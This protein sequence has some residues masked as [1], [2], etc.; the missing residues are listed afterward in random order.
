MTIGICSA[1]VGAWRD[2]GQREVLAVDVDGLA[3]PQRPQ[4]LERLAEACHPFGRVAVGD[5]EG[6]ELL[7]HRAGPDAEV[8]PAARRVGD[9]HGFTGQDSRVAE[10]VAEDEVADPQRRRPRR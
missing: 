9:G 5:A 6:V 10:R 1:G 4:D 2:P 8:E 3:G 7:G